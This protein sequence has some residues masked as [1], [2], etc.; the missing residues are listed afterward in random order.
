VNWPARCAFA[1]RSCRWFFVTGYAELC[2]L[3]LDGYSIIQ[4]PFR[5]EQ[6]ANKIHLALREGSLADG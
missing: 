4:K 6:L 3:G 5:E 2:E 1:A